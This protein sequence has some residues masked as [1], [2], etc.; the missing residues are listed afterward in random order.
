MKVCNN[1]NKIKTNT[2]WALL[3]IMR[4]FVEVFFS[5]DNFKFNF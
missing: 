5:R 4:Q 3:K 1:L 2:S